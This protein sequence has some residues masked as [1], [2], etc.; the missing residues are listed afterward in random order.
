M[1]N[2]LVIEDSPLVLKVLSRQFSLERGLSPILCAS[3]AEAK[4]MLET[5]AE[6]FDAAIADLNLPDA[7]NGEIV[8]LILAHQVPCIVLTGQYDE[9][10]RDDFFMK[11]VVDYVIK[12]SQFSYDYVFQ[13]IHR[14]EKNRKIKV[15]V[16]EDSSSARHFITR[17]LDSHRYQIL[18][19]EDG[20]SALSELE[21]HQDIDLLIIDHDMPGMLGFEVVKRVRHKMKRDIM[22]LGI[23]ADPKGSLSAM[24]IKHG[25]DD[26]LR[27]PFCAEELTCRVMTMVERREMTQ[28][29]RQAALFDSLTGLYNRRA[30]FSEG[31]RVLASAVQSKSDIS[32][33]ILDIDFFKLINDSLGHA[34]GD[35]ALKL[36]AKAL[37][38]HCPND[39]LVRLGGEEFGLLSRDS[40][41][42]VEQRLN[43]LRDHCTRMRY[44][45]AAQV[46]LN[47]SAGI[48]TAAD[49]SLEQMMLHADKLLYEAKEHGRQQTRRNES[50]ATS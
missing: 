33:A 13:L 48:Y 24:F 30:F 1:R 6:L 49:L 42:Q 41:E 46:P 23:S 31:K 14:L 26:F 43:G 25:A 29:L 9:Q 28:A 38:E 22:I 21:K 37:R 45:S 44:V 15:L 4:L 12:E 34:A 11:G 39:T 20:L 19:V 32:V 18:E 16:A 50:V 40:G 7:P 35:N 10:R 2:I 3:Y 47:F 27:K 8:D 5:S 36:F 17:V